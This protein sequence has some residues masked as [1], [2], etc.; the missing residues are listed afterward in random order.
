LESDSFFSTRARRK[1]EFMAHQSHM[2]KEQNRTEWSDF[3]KRGLKMLY[4]E[5]QPDQEMKAF[6]ARWGGVDRKTLVRVLA[7]GQGEDRLLAICVIGESDLPQA[8]TLLLPFLQSVHPQERWLSAL[9]LGRKKEKLALPVLIT[10]LTEYLPSEGFPTPEDMM[11]FDELR[12]SV[13][14]T[15][16]LWKDASLIADF[17][18]ALATSVKAEQYLPDHPV[19]RRIILLNWYIYQDGLSYALGSKGAF[20]ALLGIPLSPRRQRI[21]M[22]HMVIGYKRVKARLV[23]SAFEYPWEQEGEQRTSMKAVLEQRFGLS[24]EE[25]EYYLNHFKQDLAA[26]ERHLISGEPIQ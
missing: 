18:R 26:R 14:S 15:L 8:R 13:V 21:A 19:Q 9:Y 1:E 23:A 2:N 11:R 24:E 7:E 3:L 17:R 6:I 4:G 16:L 25:Q 22:L 10:M 20:G 5:Y 12:G